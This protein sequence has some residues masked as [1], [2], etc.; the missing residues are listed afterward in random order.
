MSASPIFDDNF[1][2]AS[3]HCL[4]SAGCAESIMAPGRILRCSCTC[5][6]CCEARDRAAEIVH[7]KSRTRESLIIHHAELR[8][9]DGQLRQFDSH[10][11]WRTFCEAEC[12]VEASLLRSKGRR[13]IRY[14]RPNSPYCA[15]HQPGAKFGNHH[16]R[17]RER[18]AAKEAHEARARAAV[19][20]IVQPPWLDG[21][22]L[23]SPWLRS[24][25]S[26][27]LIA[28]RVVSHRRTGEP[29]A[30]CGHKPSSYWHFDEELDVI[31]CHACALVVVR[32]RSK[33]AD[34]KSG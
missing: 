20:V 30:L 16:T 34:Q 23:D 11:R 27:S 2:P 9:A 5:R 7:N 3:G 12:H 13:C 17:D 15:S 29:R 24:A 4:A 32:Q 8:N 1:G 19:I 26:N 18:A 6:R 28:H 33:M 14:A 31:H 22:L 10:G 25:G 21:W